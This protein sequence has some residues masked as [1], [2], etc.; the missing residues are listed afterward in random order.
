M[1]RDDRGAVL[2]EAAFVLPVVIVLL[3]GI[4]E[5]GLAF[6]DAL[7][8]SSATRA[9][10]RTATALSKQLNYQ[11]STGQAVSGVLRNIIPSQQIQVLTIYKADPT[12]GDP[13]NGSFE[14]CTTCYIYT[15]NPAF[16][17]T[18]GSLGGWVQSGGTGWA[19]TAQNACG[20][21]AHTD[22]IGIYVRVRHPYITKLFGNSITLKDHSVMRLEPIPSASG[23]LAT[24]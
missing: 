24:T 5:F 15:W 21:T 6:K 16:V 4:I 22:Y 18:D 14:T 3:F 11:T 23:C 20:D 19:A 9:G 8:V 13:I 17:N 10:A 7:T 12:T 1:R 2:V